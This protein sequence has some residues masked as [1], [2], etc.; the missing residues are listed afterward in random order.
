MRYF[1]TSHFP[2]GTMAEQPQETFKQRADKETI[3]R[4]TRFITKLQ[5]EVKAIK[6]EFHRAECSKRMK[7]F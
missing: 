4:F 3:E 7:R 5:E 2:T 6:Q 1:I